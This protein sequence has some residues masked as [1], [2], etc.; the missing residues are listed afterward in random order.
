LRHANTLI[1]EA[2]SEPHD[3]IRL[4]RLVS[5]LETLAVVSGGKKSEALAWRCAFAGGW[6]DCGHV[7]QIVDDVLSA[8]SV[9]NEVVHGDSP[10]NEDAVSAFYRL[11]RH[12]APVYIGFLHMHAKVQ[13][14]YRPM[15][16]R[17]I[18]VA[19]DRHIE[20]FFWGLEEGW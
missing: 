15:H 18:R 3:R 7:L 11:E 20:A 16:V 1:A 4:V 8:Y 6:T 12:L 9:R 14:R 13:R 17:H 19:F 10:D 5:A 2:F